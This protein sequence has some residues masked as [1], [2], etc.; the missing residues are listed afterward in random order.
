MVYETGETM[1]Q[2]IKLSQDN[3]I[4]S[5]LEA[6][7]HHCSVGDFAKGIVLMKPQHILL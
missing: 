3:L 2:V 6:L 1:K 4:L 5:C 7:V